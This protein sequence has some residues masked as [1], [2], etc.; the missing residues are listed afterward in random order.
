MPPNGRDLRRSASVN[1][2]IILQRFL[3]STGRMCRDGGIYMNSQQLSFINEQESDRESL[4]A[5]RGASPASRIRLQES[6]KHLLTN[7]ICGLKCGESLAKLA[8]DGSWVKMYRG[9][10]QAR[11]D[12]SLE[13]YSGI[14]PKWGMMLDGVVTELP[15][16]ERFTPEKELRLLP[17]PTASDTRGL[18]DYQ[19]TISRLKNGERAHTG[20][21][22][23]YLMVLTGK[24]GRV[25]PVFYEMMMGLPIG[26]T[27]LEP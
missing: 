20:Q 21:L 13:E 15:M 12:G 1:G 2:R 22:P 19:K 6:V 4:P 27:E 14:L 24:R 25:N 18:N 9:C 10:C 7:V 16:S 11:M 23:N 5:Y 3:R 26:W 8:P 17:T